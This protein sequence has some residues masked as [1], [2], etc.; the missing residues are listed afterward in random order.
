MARQE[1][2]NSRLNETRQLLKNFYDIFENAIRNTF[3]EITEVAKEYRIERYD[4]DLE[5]YINGIIFNFNT[6][7]DISNNSE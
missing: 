1:D 3:T 5:R 2:K 7:M 4:E 6:F